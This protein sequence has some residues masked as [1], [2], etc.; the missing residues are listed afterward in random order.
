MAESLKGLNGIIVVADDILVYG[1][2]NND[3][4]ASIDHDRKLEAL[5]CVVMKET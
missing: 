4:E 1:T 3:E 2:G 5:L